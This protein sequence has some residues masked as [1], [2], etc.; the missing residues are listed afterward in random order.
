L[1]LGDEIQEKQYGSHPKFLK[2]HIW[3]VGENANM[4]GIA[5]L[6]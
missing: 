2:N 3:N 6:M 4:A 5:V 1:Q